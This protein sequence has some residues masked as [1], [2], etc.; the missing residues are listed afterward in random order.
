MKSNVLFFCFIIILI[1]LALPQS[2]YIEISDGPCI[3]PPNH[4]YYTL[5]NF[6]HSSDYIRATHSDCPISSLTFKQCTQT[7]SGSTDNS[8]NC[9]Y[10]N[11]QDVLCVL[12]E[13]S[14]SSLPNGRRYNITLD[15]KVS[16][17]DETQT[18]TFSVSVPH[19]AR[20]GQSKSCVRGGH[21][22][23]AKNV[24]VPAPPSG[25]EYREISVDI[26]SSIYSQKKDQITSSTNDT[27][28]VNDVVVNDNPVNVNGLGHDTQSG[29]SFIYSIILSDSIDESVLEEIKQTQSQVF[30][31]A[32]DRFTI[33]A[34]SEKRDTSTTYQVNVMADPAG[35]TTAGILG[36]IIGGLIGIG[37]IVG[38][39]VYFRL[40]KT[41]N[42]AIIGK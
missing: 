4:K 39:I 40:R 36:I 23:C 11:D 41:H 28:I 18:V 42:Y 24:P 20:G 38:L 26:L 25:T 17:T 7:E 6:L 33:T 14:G 35:I 15:I 16:C 32:V 2:D 10:I 37:I 34:A 30:D 13:R 19:D 21:G 3:W 1:P 27:L 12:A 8:D 9:Q 31:L 29:N 5:T 22:Y